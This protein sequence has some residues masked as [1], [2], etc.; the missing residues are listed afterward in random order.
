MYID[1]MQP[2][3]LTEIVTRSNDFTPNVFYTI[4]TPF[5]VMSVIPG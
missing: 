3:A 1:P 5:N 2:G 4:E